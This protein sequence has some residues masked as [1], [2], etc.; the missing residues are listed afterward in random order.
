MVHRAWIIGLM[1]NLQEATSELER[2]LQVARS[3]A[4]P[5]LHAIL[6][7]CLAHA[8]A[9]AGNRE[10]ALPHARRELDLG[11][12]TGLH[13]IEVSAYWHLGAVHL[14]SAAWDDAALALERGLAIVREAHSGAFYETEILERL[15]EAYAGRGEME[16]AR[17]TAEEAISLA[18]QRRMSYREASAHLAMARVLSRA[19]A[20][21]AAI[22]EH[23]AR[24][25]TLVEETGAR[26]FEP[27]ILEERAR[28]SLRAGDRQGFDRDLRAAQRLF[29]EMGATGHAERLAKELAA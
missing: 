22:E 14:L 26:I 23:L 7:S 13:H 12:R 21:S 15:A 17:Q 5:Q 29:A 11:E 25:S 6:H 2:V 24:A 10:S 28:L 19:D 9:L 20:P 16:H 18:R 3:R 27:A 1:G 4:E 8:H